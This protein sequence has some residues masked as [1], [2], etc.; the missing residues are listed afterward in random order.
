[1]STTLIARTLKATSTWDSYTAPDKI[2]NKVDT[3]RITA[4]WTAL[5]KQRD[6]FNGNIETCLERQHYN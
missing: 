1:M 2:P 5:A 6:I 4:E 3:K